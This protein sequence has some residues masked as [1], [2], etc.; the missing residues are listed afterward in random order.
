MSFKQLSLAF[1]P[2]IWKSEY[3]VNQVYIFTLCFKSDG[4]IATLWYEDLIKKESP[5]IAE[6]KTRFFD[7]NDDTYEL[8]ITSVTDNG[9]VITLLPIRMYMPAESNPSF[10]VDIPGFGEYNFIRYRPLLK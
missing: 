6:G 1:L 4:S 9:N 3:F 2:D 5:I 8:E 7:N 10:I